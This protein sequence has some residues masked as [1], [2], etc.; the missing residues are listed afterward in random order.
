MG[1][2]LRG[3]LIG[4]IFGV[5]GGA[6]GALAVQRTFY[7][8]RRAGLLTGLGSSCA[9]SFYACAGIFGITLISDFIGRHEGVIR[10]AG[11]CMILFIGIRLLLRKQEPEPEKNN[12]AESAGMCLSS[13]A[14]G[15]TN[16]ATI[17]LF[18]LA[19]SYFGISAEATTAQRLVM[20]C[21]VF[22]GT[23]VWWGMIAAVVPILKRKTVKFK[24]C[25][26]N[27][28]FGTILCLLG[29][30]ML[31][32]ACFG[33]GSPEAPGSLENTKDTQENTQGRQEEVQD[34]Q[35]ETEEI[36]EI[37][38]SILSAEEEQELQSA[39]MEA[40]KECAEYCSGIRSF[41]DGQRADVVK[42]LGEQGL[43]SVS[44][45][46]NMEN[47]QRVE[48]FYSA[49]ISGE[50]AMVTV[51]DVSKEGDICARTFIHRDGKPG[52]YYVSV[53]WREEGIPGIKDF[54]MNDL[55][56]IRMTEKGYF[57]YTA[58][59]TIMH[60][61]LREYYRVKPLPDPCRELTDKYVYGL[62]YVNYNML[63]TNWDSGNIEDILMP[64]MFE[65]IYRIHTGENLAAE[66]GLIPAETY[67]AI[68]TT[69][70]PVSAEQLRKHCGYRADTDSYEYEM[71]FPKQ[72]PPFGEVVDYEK[73]G[74]GT[75]TL[76]VDG[77]WIDYD[78]DCA[79][80]NRIVV[81]PFEDGTFR[82]LSNEVEQDFKDF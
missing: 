14:I 56:E 11:G 5:P 80:K 39:A 8:G 35:E 13:F 53:G 30:A 76:Y 61:N 29:A 10:L 28:V 4:I 15:M 24:I 62:S 64:C 82:Y 71:I 19:F 46:V 12:A 27:R 3:F 6:I 77:V 47:Y 22:F 9:D 66:N 38:D 44:D 79:F 49:Y 54:G 70:F 16:P 67:E 78:S 81:L 31:V 1:Y 50:N 36:E 59:K 69:Y 55:E 73:N 74:D 18:L 45:S 60:G 26:M 63:V 41:S 58:R 20:V 65:D 32:A 43:V 34:R 2:L 51:F 40:A 57:I 75:L 37:H 7:Y 17:F 72:F 23:Y 42:C 68:M 52:F 25:Y 33:G 21:G 48:E